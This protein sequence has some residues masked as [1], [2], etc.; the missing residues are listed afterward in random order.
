M[1]SKLFYLLGITAI[2]FF[3]LDTGGDCLAQTPTPPARP[4]LA[5]VPSAGEI[6]K[7]TDLNFAKMAADSGIGK[8][9]AY[10]AADSAT[11]FRRGSEPILGREA[12]RIAST[13]TSGSA[14]RWAPY[15]A[16]IA[17]SNDLGYTLGQSQYIYKDSTGTEK[18]SYG[19][20][21]TIWKKQPDGSWKYVLDT[22]VSAPKPRTTLQELYQPPK[23]PKP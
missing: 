10:F 3:L 23:L 18:I 19:Y 2:T 17:A 9:F 7:Q 11:L 21:V 6:L 16:D 14:L 12:I 5:A 15:F 1:T 4:P 20:Y 13:D 8:A 22:G